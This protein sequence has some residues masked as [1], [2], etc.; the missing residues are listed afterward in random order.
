MDEK[1]LNEFNS[2]CGNCRYFQKYYLNKGN[3]F[4]PSFRGR[5][6]NKNLTRKARNALLSDTY[7][8]EC[9]EK[10]DYVKQEKTKAIE[11]SLRD[12]AKKLDIIAQSLSIDL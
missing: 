10:D 9:W 4:A 12:I 8:C 2:R 11:W 5:Y 3:R 1:N 7:V 6:T